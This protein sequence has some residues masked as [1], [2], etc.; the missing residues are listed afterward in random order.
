MTEPW[1]IELTV[2]VPRDEAPTVDDAID[3]VGDRLRPLFW[4]GR[5]SEDPDYGVSQRHFSSGI[6]FSLLGSSGR[7]GKTITKREKR[8]NAGLCN[9]CLQAALRAEARRLGGKA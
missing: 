8:L 9:S 5:I 2:L 1:K 3:T 6:S 4:T 7:T